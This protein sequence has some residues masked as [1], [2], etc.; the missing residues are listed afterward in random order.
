MTQMILCSLL[1]SDHASRKVYFKMYMSGYFLADRKLKCTFYGNQFDIKLSIVHIGF[2]EKYMIQASD[3]EHSKRSEQTHFHV[4][5]V[6]L[7]C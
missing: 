6:L 1:L 5:F 7:M 4:N 3:K 2:I